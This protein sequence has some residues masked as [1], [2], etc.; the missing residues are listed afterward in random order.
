MDATL[1]I[2]RACMGPRVSWYTMARVW[3]QFP[4]SRKWKGKEGIPPCLTIHINTGLAL[5]AMATCGVLTAR[6][7]ASESSPLKDGF[8]LGWQETFG[9]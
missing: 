1:P 2:P 7:A 3:P 4:H 9:E 8:I 6:K 5:Q